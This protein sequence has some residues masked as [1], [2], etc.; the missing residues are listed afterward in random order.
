MKAIVIGATGTIGKAV[1][2]LFREK[3]HEVV[4]A[5]RSSEYPVDID[6]PASIDQFYSK[7]DAV[8]AII[9]AAGNAS[10][11]ALKNLT[12]EQIALGLHSKLLG[13]INVARKGIAK[14]KPNGVIVLTGGML[15]YTPWPE[16]TNIAAV[17][18]GVEG[19][20]KAAAL[21]L[22]EGKRI[23]IV[24]PP[25]VRETAQAMG[26]EASPWPGAATVA[27]TYL[28]AVEGNANGEVVFVEG[29]Q[30]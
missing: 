22:E 2:S 7:L 13:Q 1:T 10:F 8:D 18:A 30:P 16:T 11:G 9:C 3:G 17:N 12:D 29:Y 24:H 27:A 5:S 20:T 21:E 4:A 23:L 19:F 25:F 15:A 26:M 28:K 6:Q 14:L